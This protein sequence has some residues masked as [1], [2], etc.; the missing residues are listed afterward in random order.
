MKNNFHEQY[1][2][3]TRQE[4]KADELYHRIATQ[5]GLSNSAFWTL[6]C[7]C[8]EDE[9]YTQN[10]LAETLGI[11]KQTLNSTVNG[12]MQNGYILLEKMSGAR[13]SKSIHLTE[14]GRSF[15]KRFILPTRNAEESALMRMTE[16]EIESYLVLSRKQ[17]SFLHEELNA[18]LEAIRSEQQ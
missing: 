9:T 8:E 7:L 5:I 15:C 12:L 6:F 4:R 17:I 18:F 10:T 13:N 2:E 1:A 16:I 11:P 3:L 14:K